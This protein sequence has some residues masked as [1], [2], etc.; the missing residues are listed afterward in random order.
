MGLAENVACVGEKINVY[1]ILTKNLRNETACG[2]SDTWL[3]IVKVNSV[4]V[5]VCVCFKIIF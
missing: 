4:C 3:D 5:C 2:T 1:L